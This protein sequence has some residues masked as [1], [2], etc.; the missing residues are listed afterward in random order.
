[1]SRLWNWFQQTVNV[2]ERPRFGR[3][4]CTRARQ[5]RYL[6]DLARRRRFQSAFSLYVDFRRATG[7][8][9]STQTIRNRPFGK[10]TP[11]ARPVLTRMHRIARRQ[12]SGEH[13]TCQLRQWRHVFFTDE[14]RI[15]VDFHDGRRNV[16]HTA[17]ERHADCCVAQHDR[18]GE[19]LSWYGQAS[20]LRVELTCM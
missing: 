1:M 20:V 8:Q 16:W 4:R 17:G 5:D 2:S 15:C 9:M 10:F 11:A 13:V 12:W 3:P 7:K 6:D 19:G 18:F 14:S